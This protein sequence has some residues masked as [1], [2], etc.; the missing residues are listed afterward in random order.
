[1]VALNLI[2]LNNGSA[3]TFVRGNSKSFIDI[4]LVKKCVSRTTKNWTV[5][6]EEFINFEVGD[7]RRNRQRMQLTSK[8]MNQETLV[9]T[10]EFVKYNIQKSSQ[11]TEISTT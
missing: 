9:N 5:S 11:N 10:L 6:V 3:P 8:N 1:M 7:I 2:A 4:I